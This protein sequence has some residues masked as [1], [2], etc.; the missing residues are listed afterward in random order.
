MSLLDLVV[1]PDTAVGHLA[2]SLG[3]Q[4]WIALSHVGEWRWMV[5]GD[6]TP[7]YP[8]IRIFRQ[9]KLNDWE[10]VF[11]RMADALRQGPFCPRRG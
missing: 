5:D 10:S 1:A 4:A 8:S 6:N 11:R 7:W 3:V 2:G 9:T